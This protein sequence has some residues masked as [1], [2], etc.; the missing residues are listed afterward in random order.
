[1][2]TPLQI[3]TDA[4]ALIDSPEKWIQGWFNNWRG[5]AECHCALGAII[6]A[7]DSFTGEE[8]TVEIMHRTGIPVI[9]SWN[10][11]PARTH[12]EVMAA[13]DTAIELARNE[14]AK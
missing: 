4:R 12:A 9:T 14:E 11:D 8:K 1:M 5:D 7:S 10:D 13:F 6:K 3:L 2:K